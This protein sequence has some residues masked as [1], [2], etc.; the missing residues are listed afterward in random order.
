ML[1]NASLKF[2]STV[3]VCCRWGGYVASRN[4]TTTT[5]FACGSDPG[6]TGKL[7]NWPTQRTMTNKHPRIPRIW[8]GRICP[9]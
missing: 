9:S 4:I 3:P 8:G 2:I 7:A 6:Q 1:P 5:M